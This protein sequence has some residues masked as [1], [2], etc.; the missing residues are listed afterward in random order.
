M[1]E[2]DW[3]EKYVDIEGISKEII[4]GAKKLRIKGIP[5]NSKGLLVLMALDEIRTRIMETIANMEYREAK[6]K[7]EKK[8]AEKAMK[9]AEQWRDLYKEKL[10][11][12][13]VGTT[14]QNKK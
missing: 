10:K 7:L 14:E 11:P 6:L 12:E 5:V 9:E 1:G 8:K 2:L 13:N 3:V 4:K